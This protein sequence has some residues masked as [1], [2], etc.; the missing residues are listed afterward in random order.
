MANVMIPRDESGKMLLPGKSEHERSWDFAA[1]SAVPSDITVAAGT[2]TVATTAAGRGELRMVTGA[3]IGN[4]AKITLPQVDLAFC[5]TVAL[6]LESVKT[7]ATD[8]P[9]AVALGLGA[10]G[11]GAFIKKEATN[12][13][14]Y[15]KYNGSSGATDT[16]FALFAQGRAES[17]SFSF[18]INCRKKM[19]YILEGDQVA[20]AVEMPSMVLGLITPDFTITPTP[21]RRRPRR[22]QGSG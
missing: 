2:V 6:T 16:K 14:M 18:L 13:Y 3:T 20:A 4:T 15:I 5:E 12:L 17:V 7:S 19:L 22:Y 8:C 21:P 10:S 1:L 11:I 9:E